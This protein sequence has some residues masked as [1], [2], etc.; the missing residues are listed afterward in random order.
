M[1]DIFNSDLVAD[2]A[3]RR[4]VL[5]LGAGV[6]ASAKTDSG[7]NFKDWKGVLEKAS[8]SIGDEGKRALVQSYV[9]KGDFLLASELIKKANP[10]A[11]GELLRREFSKTAQ[12]SDL[13]RAIFSLKQRIIIT[14]NFDKLLE[15]F[16]QPLTG[17]AYYPN[18]KCKVDGGVFSMLRD[19]ESYIIKLHGTADDEDS[20]IFDKSSYGASAYGNPAYADLLNVLLLTHTFLFIGF[21]MEDPAISFV[22]E[23]FARKYPKMRPHYI[24]LGE[25]L[26]NDVADIWK[27]L[28]KLYVMSYD[29]SNNHGQLVDYIRQLSD[30]AVQKRKELFVEVPKGVEVFS[31]G[32]A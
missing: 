29:S 3:N 19:D 26:D 20:I 21:S 13:H 6:S 18:V 24:F 7:D 23:T 5:F 28:R 17:D 25:E 2:V 15:T 31:E 14:T 27:S 22:V 12:P 4:V 1:S 32:D 11:W 9:K 30:L 8:Q 10:T 16:Y